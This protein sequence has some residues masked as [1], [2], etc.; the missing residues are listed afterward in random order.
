MPSSS[1]RTSLARYVPI[2]TVL[3]ATV[4][5]GVGILAIRHSE[6]SGNNLTLKA[7]SADLQELQLR[8]IRLEK[9]MSDA[10]QSVANLR[11]R[12]DKLEEELAPVSDDGAKSRLEELDK[13]IALLE[14]RRN[15]GHKR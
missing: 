3:F 5:I 2:I 4:G 14:G 13:R 6:D 11:A 1:E 12:V 7:T 8:E 10:Q 15:Q 9:S